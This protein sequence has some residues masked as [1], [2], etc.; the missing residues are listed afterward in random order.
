MRRLRIIMLVAL[1]GGTLLQTT[2]TSCTDTLGSAGADLLVS[3]VLQVLLGG[4]GT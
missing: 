3:I 4:L 2:S 1:C